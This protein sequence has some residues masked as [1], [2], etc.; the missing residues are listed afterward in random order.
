MLEDNL[1]SVITPAWKAEPFIR[2]TIDSVKA[3]TYPQWEMIVVDDCSPDNTF[4]IV[5]EIARTD[6]RVRLVRHERNGGPALARNTGVAAAR[7]RWLAMLDGDD[8]WLPQ[9]LEKQLAFHRQVGGNLTYTGWRRVTVDGTRPGRLIQVPATLNYSRLL[10]NTA[11]ATSTVLIDRKKAGEVH[12][13]NIY[14]D[15]FGCW[16]DL[17][18]SGGF[19]YGLQEELMRYRVVNNSVSRN[20]VRSA[21][22]VWKTYRRVEGL[23]LIRSAFY[24]SSYCVHAIGKYMYF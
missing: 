22:E 11:I 23:G 9:K 1:V 5:T 8:Q 20:K 14:Y 16:L 18:R 15:D 24:F 2:A 3:Q 13:K 10:G 21:G 6:P 7:G 4:G 12:F 19:A 17:L